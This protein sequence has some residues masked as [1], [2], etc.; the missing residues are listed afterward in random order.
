VTDAP[1]PGHASAGVDALIARLENLAVAPAG[2][3]RPVLEGVTLDV[4]PGEC[5]ALVGRSGSGKTT[6]LRTMATLL[7]PLAGTMAVTGIDP[8]TVSGDELRRL[9]C[10]IGVIAQRGDL[11]EP[12]RVDRN[13]MAGALGRWSNRRALRHL[14]RPTATEQA[15]AATALAAVGLEDKLHS[16]TSQLSGGEQQ[17]VAIARTLVQAPA[18][19]L[20]DEPVA[21]LDPQNARDVLDLLTSLAR[22]RGMGVVMALHQP[23]LAALFCER[24]FTLSD[25]RLEQIA[26]SS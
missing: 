3:T 8:A 12:L 20:A 22:E 11:V 25:G 14:L 5:V 10:R 15:E 23:D 9:R 26:A 1:P 7:P 24:V 16:R 6:L 17:R 4:R 13:V 21:S 18:L 19:L 2:V